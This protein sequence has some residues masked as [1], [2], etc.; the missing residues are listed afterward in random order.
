MVIMIVSFIVINA[1]YNNS[2]LKKA[3]SSYFS[4]LFGNCSDLKFL[5]H[6]ID[7][8]LHRSSIS[9]TDPPV[10]L[11]AH[12]FSSFFT[13]KIKSHRAN[14]LLIDANPFSFPD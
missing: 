10:S 1:D 5:W 6:S 8:V 4:S 2:L 14:L 12:Q 11:S 7:K 3:Q 13:D 9:N